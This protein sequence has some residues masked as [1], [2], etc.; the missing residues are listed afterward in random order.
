MGP[1]TATA[2]AIAVPAERPQNLLPPSPDRALIYQS[3]RSGPTNAPAP[4]GTQI[5][6]GIEVPSTIQLSPV[7]ETAARLVPETRGMQAGL[8]DRRVIIVEPSSRKIVAVIGFDEK[9]DLIE[10]P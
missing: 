2:E 4:Q 8:V 1:G 9:R 6:L 10:K 3:V 5:A 7:P